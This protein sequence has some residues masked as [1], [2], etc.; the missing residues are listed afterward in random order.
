MNE[1]I[2]L[3]KDYQNFR[4]HYFEGSN[5]LFEQLVEDGQRPKFLIIACCDSRVDPAII[6]GAVPGELFVV[7][8]VAN[9]VPPC[10]KDSKHHATSAALEFA[11]CDLKVKHIIIWGHKD[12]GGIQ[13]LLKNNIH[14]Q[15][16]DRGFIE[17]WMNI[18]ASARQK[19][20]QEYANESFDEQVNH[21]EKMAMQVSLNNLL[22]FPWIKEK[23]DTKELYIHAWYFDLSTGQIQRLNTESNQFEPLEQMLT[24]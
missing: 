8:N 6:T 3:V 16:E 13:A 15:E 11:V 2:K 23:V 5:Q 14:H 22:T 12:C 19:V 7:R 10:E 20:L 4:E 9:L 24:L 18:A 1:L 21:C 17:N